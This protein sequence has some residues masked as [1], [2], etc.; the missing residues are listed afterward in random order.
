MTTPTHVELEITMT[1]V[2]VF[3]VVHLQ[4]LQCAM[5]TFDLMDSLVVRIEELMEDRAT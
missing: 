3:L 5:V 1:V 4:V 2:E